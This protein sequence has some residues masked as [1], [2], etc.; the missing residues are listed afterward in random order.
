[1]YYAQASWQ[2]IVLKR[3]AGNTH[4]HKVYEDHMRLLQGRDAAR[5]TRCDRTTDLN[6][7]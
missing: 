2:A 1:M 5:Y 6:W 7:H 3:I 4:W